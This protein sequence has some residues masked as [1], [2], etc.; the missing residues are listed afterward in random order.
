V[1]LE[2]SQ[3][4]VSFESLLVIA[5]NYDTQELKLCVKEANQD[6]YQIRSN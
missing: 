3:K 2:E 4:V 5:N 6:D 1:R